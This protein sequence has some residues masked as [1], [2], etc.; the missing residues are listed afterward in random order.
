M[1]CAPSPAVSEENSWRCVGL[2]PTK[3]PGGYHLIVDQLLQIS[4]PIWTQNSAKKRP[5]HYD[6]TPVPGRATLGLDV[7]ALAGY[8]I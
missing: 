4:N 3:T 5:P 2:A 8:S 7:A 1:P 6:N